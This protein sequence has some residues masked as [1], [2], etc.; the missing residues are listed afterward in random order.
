MEVNSKVDKIDDLIEDLYNLRK[1]GMKQENGEYSILNLIFKEFRNLGYL[2]NLKELRKKEIS[3]E[4]S[5]EQLNEKT[6]NPMN[7]IK[8]RK[9]KNQFDNLIT[10]LDSINVDINIE[11]EDEINQIYI[12][13]CLSLIDI[14][15][16]RAFGL[17]EDALG[18][19]FISF[20][21]EMDRLDSYLKHFNSKD[22]VKILKER[23]DKEIYP[24]LFE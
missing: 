17:F 6:N 4:L 7:I 12:N 19:Y 23:F 16:Q 9:I 8:N 3:K 10:Y 2:D 15:N 11:F 24:S 1:E 21:L 20:G 22:A 18:N 14:D 13:K 5:L